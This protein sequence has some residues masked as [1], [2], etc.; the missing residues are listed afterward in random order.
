MEISIE[1]LDNEFNLFIAM[2]APKRLF[3]EWLQTVNLLAYTMDC[4][5]CGAN[6]TLQSKLCKIDGCTWRCTGEGRH[7]ISV[8]K[9]SLFSGSHLYAPDV[10]NFIVKY[11]EGNLLWKC[12]HSSGLTYHSIAGLWAKEI[13]ETVLSNW[14]LSFLDTVAEFD[15][16]GL[17][18]E[19]EI[20]ESVFGR[21]VKYFVGNPFPG[22][23]I[24]ILGLVERGTNRVLLFPIDD[25]KG[26]TLDA[27]IQ[28]YVLPGATIYTDGW[29]G[30]SRLNHLGYEH[31][32]VIHKHGFKVTY[33]NRETGVHRVCHTNT[34]EGRWKHDC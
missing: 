8:R 6:C 17:Y 7:A 26:S 4:P 19:V 16:F 1:D 5:R 10:L 2:L 30:Y 27:I 15:Q 20:D 25:R 31:Y 18:G 34:M 9:Y 11:G 29:R 21:R 12:A 14:V 22:L 24:W 13:R 33:I 3:V 23:T 28:K 32:S